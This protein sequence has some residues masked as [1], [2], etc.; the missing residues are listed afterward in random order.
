MLLLT[1]DDSF[2][3]MF[4]VI[5]IFICLLLLLSI[6]FRQKWCHQPRAI[7]NVKSALLVIAHP[8]DEC[9]FVVISI[10][11]VS[12]YISIAGMFF[13]PTIFGLLSAGVDIYVLCL[14]GGSRKA[15]CMRKH[16]MKEVLLLFVN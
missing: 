13:A 3:I 7:A 5:A 8:D 15:H 14:T 6:L 1:I 10:Q 4:Y 12:L 9:V 16:E 11:H 2:C